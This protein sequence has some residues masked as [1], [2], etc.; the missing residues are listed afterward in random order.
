MLPELCILI[1]NRHIVVL[2]LAFDVAG[3]TNKS[4]GV[5]SPYWR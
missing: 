1:G 2:L 3:S 4:C 5:F